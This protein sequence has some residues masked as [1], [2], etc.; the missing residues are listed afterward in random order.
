MTPISSSDSPDI[1]IPL[2][3]E[4]LSI[5][6]REVKRD[7]EIYMRTSSHDQSIDEP[8]MHETVEIAISGANKDALNAMPSFTYRG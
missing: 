3:V 4:D 2:H 7:V 5:E 1:T 6:R 8:V